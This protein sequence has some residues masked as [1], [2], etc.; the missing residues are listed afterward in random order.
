MPNDPA[1]IEPFREAGCE[2]IVQPRS[3]RNFD[4]AGVWQTYR[5]LRRLNC[6][7]FHCYNYHTDPLIGAYL[8]GVPVRIWSKLAMSPY[9]EQG[10]LPKG[11]HGLMLS[12]R[13]SCL[14]AHRVMA[15][16]NRVREE[17]V[18]SVGFRRR[19]DTVYVPVDIM[20]FAT[21][22]KGTVRQELGL[23]SSDVLI[24][25]VGH[26]VPVKG[27]DLAIQA[28]A[29]A[30]RV[31]PQVH[32]I[33]VGGIASS[34]EMKYLQYLTT[35]VRKCEGSGRIHFLGHCD[36]IPE[37]LKA[38]DVFIM[39][40]R[41]E[42]MPAALIEAMAAG[43]PCIAARVGGIPEVIGHGE[44]GLLFEREN[45]EELAA[46]MVRLAQDRMLRTRIAAR[47]SDRA[48]SFSIQ[49]YVDKVVECY[50]ILLGNKASRDLEVSAANT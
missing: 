3:R 24:A 45:V 30:S 32:L 38:C 34:E 7:V 14:C 37:I 26:A 50:K 49:A 6:D 1:L 40:S 35:L 47:A 16:S 27:W 42:G 4:I 41:S 5:L 10:I 25:A 17:V 8:A 11:L 15:V 20:R 48:A 31:L 18:D 46:H 44:D 22:A 2:L 13:M 9:Y 36:A 29:Q 33:L 28:F 21:A 39:P 43:L 12:T 23:D 19:I